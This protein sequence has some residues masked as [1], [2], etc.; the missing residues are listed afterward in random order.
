VRFKRLQFHAG[1]LPADIVGTIDLQ[2]QDGTFRTKHGRYSAI[3]SWA[4]EINRDRQRSKCAPG[5]HAG[6]PGHIGEETNPLSRRR[7][8]SLRRR[9]HSNKKVPT[10]FRRRRRS[11]H[12]EG[13]SSTIRRG[14]RS[15][16]FSMRLATTAE[17]MIVP[18]TVV[19]RRTS[20]RCSPRGEMLFVDDKI[21]RLHR[22][23][24]CSRRV[25]PSRRGWT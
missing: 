12:D 16:R 11:V 18:R 7:F 14:L 23:Y 2:P 4:D 20:R 3:S 10:L 8:C 9:T 1:L 6:A 5:G 15:G 19:K 17:P 21:R 13:G 22:R 25:R 24:P